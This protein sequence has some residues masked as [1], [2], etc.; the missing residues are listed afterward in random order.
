MSDFKIW[1][2]KDT[3]NIR[4]KPYLVRWLGEFDPHTGKQKKYSKSFVRRKDAERFV[5]QKKDEFGGGLPR[6]EQNITLEQLCSKFLKVHQREYTNGT[7]KNYE[8]TIHRLQTY[9]HPSISVK[10]IKQQHAQEF[11]AQI[12]YVRQDYAD[13]D[14]EL[15]DSS[16]NIQIRNCNKIFNVAV[17]WKYILENPF[18][19]IKQVKAATQP[20]HWITIDEF[21][22]IF[23]QTPTLQKKVFYYLLYGCGLRVGE[24]LNLLKND[25]GIDLKNGQINLTNRPA[26]KQIPPFKLKDKEARSVPIPKKVLELLKQLLN[27]ADSDCPFLLMTSERWEVVKKNWQTMRKEGRSREWE[28][29]M[30]VCNPLRDFKRTCKRAGI[31]THE[32]LNLHGLRKSWATNLADN[33]IN[34]KTLCELGGWSDPSVLNEYYNKATDANKDK[35]RQVLDDLFGE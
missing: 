29:W 26:S 27:E 9:F 2:Q 24:A 21:E 11:I 17:E 1:I 35:A 4:K 15:S 23:E 3:R 31:E 10:S 14:E 8:Y 22:A 28:N 34:Q 16:R 19:N 20:W 12:D 25:S 33:G 30:L 18:D 32:R 7:L 5:Q 13:K 6:D